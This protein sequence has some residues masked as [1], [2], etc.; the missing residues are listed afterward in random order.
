MDETNLN[1]SINWYPGHMA[2]TKREIKEKLNIIDIVLCLVDAR[3]PYSTFSLG[4]ESIIEKKPKIMVLSKYDLCDKEETSKWEN[5]YK[6]QGY[7]IIKANLKDGS[8]YKNVI[9]EIE[10]LMIPINKKRHEKGLLDQKARVL[11]LGVPNVGKSTLINKIS[12]KNKVNVGN[13]PGVTKSLSW[14]RVN[15]KIDLLD[16]PGLLVP[17]IEEKEVALNLSSMTTIKE[18]ILPIDEVAVH[19]LNKLN[20]YY[21]SILKDNYGIDEV[22]KDD[23]VETYHLIADFRGIKTKDEDEMFERVSMMIIN[24]IK[25]EKIKGITFDRYE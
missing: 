16:S 10:K 7:N 18:D 25:S 11:V 20:D 5:K 17:K 1:K 8:D 2:K 13:K 19:I 9:S 22:N 14:I 24:D 23:F 12:G 6:E 3:I 15:S 21:P 4:L